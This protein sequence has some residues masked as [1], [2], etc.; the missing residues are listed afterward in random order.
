MFECRENFGVVLL[1]A[2]ASLVDSSFP[3]ESCNL[4]QER[5]DFLHN[6]HPLTLKH[7]ISIDIT[8]T[9]VITAAILYRTSWSYVLLRFEPVSRHGWSYTIPQHCSRPALQRLIRNNIDQ[10]AR[11]LQCL[12]KLQI[13]KVSLLWRCPST[14]E[15]QAHVVVAQRLEACRTD[16]IHNV[17][18][19]CA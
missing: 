17:N 4:R 2:A 11:Y 13:C 7:F 18:M 14:R 15:C 10:V 6:S 12:E 8:Y 16:C 19:R 3:A 9:A 1:M 5:P